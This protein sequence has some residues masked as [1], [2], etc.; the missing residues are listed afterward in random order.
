MAYIIL[1]AHIHDKST[2]V[3]IPS[4]NM[5]LSV[6]YEGREHWYPLGTADSNGDMRINLGDVVPI[7]YKFKITANGYDDLINSLYFPFISS[8]EYTF[9]LNRTQQGLPPIANFHASPLIVEPREAVQFTDDST[10]DPTTWGWV[11]GDGSVS[12]LQNPTHS[13]ANP[14]LYSVYLT[15]A[16]SA[17]SSTK[18]RYNYIHVGEKPIADFHYIPV[19]PEVGDKVTFYGGDSSGNPTSYI[20]D[21]GDGNRVTVTDPIVTHTYSTE[22]SYNV[23]LTTSNSF[24]SSSKTRNIYVAMQTQPPVADFRIL[25]DSI[26]VDEVYAGSQFR[27]SNQSRFYSSVLWDLGN[28]DTSTGDSIDY[29][30]TVPGDYI[31]TLTVRNAKGDSDTE[32]KTLHVVLMPAPP[33]AC[34]VIDKTTAKTGEDITF[35]ASCSEGDGIVSYFW[36]FGDGETVL[37]QDPITT[38]AYTEAGEYSIQLTVTDSNNQSGSYLSSVT[39]EITYNYVFSVENLNIGVSS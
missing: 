2:G 35:D 11:F 10:R 34:F 36:D 30:Y 13:Y 16:N 12:T 18:S 23:T 28:G 21:F 4:A 29:T 17:G 32:S 20:W 37:T 25:Q 6:S 7:T 19:N 9:E 3:G 15:V 24:G 14:G 26:E 1:F 5:F 33:T 22:G 39:I 27:L 8:W 38:H 31:I